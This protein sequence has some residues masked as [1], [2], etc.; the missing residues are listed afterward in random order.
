[1]ELLRTFLTQKEGKKKERNKKG[2]GTNKTSSMMVDL[3][4]SH[5]NERQKLS[6]GLKK[7]ARP[8]YMFCKNHAFNVK[9]DGYVSGWKKYFITGKH[10][11]LGE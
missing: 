9:T 7:K 4:F 1:M 3:K 11:K 2:G 10:K 5:I 6:N 8:N